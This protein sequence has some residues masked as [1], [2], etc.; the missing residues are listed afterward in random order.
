MDY[1]LQLRQIVGH[2]PLVVVVAATLIV[3]A[4]NRLLLL[5]RS[6]SNCWGLPGGGVE[7]GEFVEAAARRE[8]LEETGLEL[9]E[10]AL[11]GVFSGP[12][13]YYVY[14]NGDETDNVF[15]TYLTRQT[16]G[17]LRINDEHT[18]WRWFAPAELPDPAEIS[19][20]ILPIIEQF[21]LFSTEKG[22][23]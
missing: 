3:D 6:D 9:G 4:N 1:I 20:P 13:L 12:D 22:N 10:M 17:T 15:I 18:G 11:F 23:S 8:A 5:K 2:R 19:A 16:R 21:N 7:P 14:P